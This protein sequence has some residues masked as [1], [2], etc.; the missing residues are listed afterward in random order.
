MTIIGI[1]LQRGEKMVEKI[2]EVEYGPDE[3]LV[4]RFHKPKAIV[5]CPAKEH[6][7]DSAKEMLLALRSLMDAAIKIVEE[8]EAP[9]K[10]ASTKIEVN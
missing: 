1:N 8:K 10:K 2:F 4:L 6:L 7:R 5:A 9:A 3:G